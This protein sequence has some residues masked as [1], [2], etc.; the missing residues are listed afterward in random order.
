MAKGLL[1]PV[2]ERFQA[3]WIFKRLLEE[4]GRFGIETL[5]GRSRLLSSL[6]EAHD[7]PFEQYDALRHRL[8]AGW[9]DI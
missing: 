2:R 5:G 6:I 7:A 3:E 4:F 1:A 9:H 8:L